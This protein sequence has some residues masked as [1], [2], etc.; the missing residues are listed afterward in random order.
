MPPISVAKTAVGP[1]RPEFLSLRRHVRLDK[2]ALSHGEPF[3]PGSEH[4][5]VRPGLCSLRFE[6]RQD[7]AA[8]RLESVN[9][10]AGFVGE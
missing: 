10:D 3:T 4:D 2:A 1:A 5:D 8:G 7:I 6:P 9:S